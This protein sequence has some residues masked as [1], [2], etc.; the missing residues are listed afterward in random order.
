MATPLPPIEIATL[1][2][3]APGIALIIGIGRLLDMMRTTVNVTGDAAISCIVAKREHTFDQAIYDGPDA[4]P[5]GNVSRHS[6][7]ART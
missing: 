3:M 2:D 5:D 7:S 6:L 4:G 1:A